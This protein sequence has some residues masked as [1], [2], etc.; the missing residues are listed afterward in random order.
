MSYFGY[1]AAVFSTVTTDCTV[2]Y[3]LNFAYLKH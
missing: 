1:I 2:H 3:I